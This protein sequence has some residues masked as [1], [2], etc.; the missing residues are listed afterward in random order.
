MTRPPAAL[1]VALLVPT[2]IGAA[3]GGYAGDALPVARAIAQVVDC[4]VTHPNVLNG[5]QLFWPLPNTLYVEG[6]GLDRFAAG[7]WG[8]RPVRANRL[9]IVLDRGMEPELILRHR[10]AADAVRAT[11]GI[12]IAGA[13]LTDEPLGVAL[14]QTE[15]GSWG[16]IAHPDSLL[17]A[18]ERARDELRAEAIAV[19]ARFPDDLG[20]EL[21]AVAYQQGQG[22]D[23]IAGAEAVISHWVVRELGLPCAHA[24][25][26]AAGEAIAQVAPKA[27]AEELG[28]T[29]LPCVL[30]GLAHAP[31]FVRG[32]GRR[33]GD[34]GAE[35]IHAVIIPAGAAGG[36]AVLSWA[37]AGVEVIEIV[38]NRTALTVEAAAL[39][40]ATVQLA[41][42]LEAIGWLVARRAGIDPAAVLGQVAPLAFR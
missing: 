9:A 16:T 14:I 22:L 28:Y 24:P 31:Q 30:A 6:Y 17:R 41:S 4:L 1:N 42:Y 36:S 33:R 25:A 5:A 20:S 27:A 15:R 39:G 13:V 2:G 18:A 10:Q 37:A 23:P 26:L 34:L 12:E 19:V 3:I 21:G 11:L 7:Q 40:V 35:D 32:G 38:G 29:F 8:L